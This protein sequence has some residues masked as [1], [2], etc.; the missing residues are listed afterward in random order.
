MAVNCAKP[1]FFTMPQQYLRFRAKV[2][3][4]TWILVTAVCVVTP[5]VV[6]NSALSSLF[7]VP[8][9]L[10]GLVMPLRPAAACVLAISLVSTPADYPAYPADLPLAQ[11]VAPEALIDL[12]LAVLTH[13]CLVIVVFR[14]Q[15]VRLRS[16]LRQAGGRGRHPRPAGPGTPLHDRRHGPDRPDR[17]VTMSNPALAELIGAHAGC[18]DHGVD[19]RDR[20]AVP[21]TSIASSMRRRWPRWCTPARDGSPAR[22]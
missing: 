16:H 1:V 6:P 12:L 21:W 3:L 10:A 13:V 9:V 17:P 22:R 7:V 15:T 20:T 5:Y 4:V 14:R 2:W 11:L 19:P 18:G 8:A